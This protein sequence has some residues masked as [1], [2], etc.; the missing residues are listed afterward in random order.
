MIT[1]TLMTASACT[2]DP[3]NNMS[4][5]MEPRINNAPI[6]PEDF[7]TKDAGMDMNSP[8]MQI[9]EDM[10]ARI[11]MAMDLG[12]ADLGSPDM[13]VDMSEDMGVSPIGYNL[14]ITCDAYEEC[15]QAATS[16]QP[17][18]P[19]DPE[20]ILSRYGLGGYPEETTQIQ[21][22]NRQSGIINRQ[23]GLNEAATILNPLGEQSSTGLI[24]DGTFC[25]LPEESQVRL[26]SVTEPN[27]PFDSC[28][29][30]A[31]ACTVTFEYISLAPSNWSDLRIV[32]KFECPDSSVPSVDGIDAVLTN[33]DD[34]EY[35]A[36]VSLQDTYSV[37]PN[38]CLLD[39][40]FVLI[41]ETCK[42]FNDQ[43]PDEYPVYTGE[44][45]KSSLRISR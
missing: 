29:P 13:G 27:V 6:P 5:D 7:G 34:N 10:G 32:M 16:I 18:T 38:N 41:A 2:E 26:I 23:P 39:P 21:E 36:F 4:Q 24:V 28:E 19:N 14:D 31:E 42:N 44:R 9:I 11:D 25:I 3:N 1:A 33:P 12:E 30:T 37:S 17:R 20:Y 43:I 22:Q 45:F 8:D 40:D 15:L 35:S